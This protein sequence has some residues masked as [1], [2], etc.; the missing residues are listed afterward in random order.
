MARN[1]VSSEERA[2]I[3][4][5]LNDGKS[6]G[7]VAKE[8]KRSKSTI[9]EIANK[10]GISTERSATKKASE[11]HRDYAQAERLLLLNE[12]FDKARDVLKHIGL[13]DDLKDWSVAVGTLID[14]RR[15]EDGKA[16]SR[17]E[18]ADPE[19]RRKMRD[20]LDEVS[21]RRRQNMAG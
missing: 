17:H 1:G 4:S 7:W 18:N 15:L 13:A 12:G 21:A 11:A 20:T 10:A 6:Q 19:R 9:S 5:Y 16:T 3:V 14:K 8:E 2:R